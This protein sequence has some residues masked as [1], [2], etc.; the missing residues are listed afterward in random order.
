MLRDQRIEDL[1][2]ISSFE[3]GALREVAAAGPGLPLA[4]L[5]GNDTYRPDVRLREAWPF[6]ALRRHGAAAWHPSSDLPLLEQLIPRV[7]RAGYAVN[8]WTVDDVA[9][10][11]RLIALEVD[12]IIT[13][14]PDVLRRVVDG[15]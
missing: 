4:Y 5:M 8:V 6:G 15:G 1:V 7:R 3:A 9:L 2:L 12:G 13:N 11:R 14:V 10:M